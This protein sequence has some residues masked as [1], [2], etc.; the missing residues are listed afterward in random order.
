MEYAF[1]GNYLQR[2]VPSYLPKI[3][4]SG[5]SE[6]V[7]FGIDTSRS[8]LNLSIEQSVDLL[9]WDEAERAALVRTEGDVEVFQIPVLRED[10]SPALFFR[11]HAEV[12]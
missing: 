7:E 11:V 1:G 4:S 8:D 10:G 2:D 5:D 3:V 12:K 9:D 6:F